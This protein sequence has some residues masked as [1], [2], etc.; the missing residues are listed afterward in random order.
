MSFL[1]LL[2]AGCIDF[3]DDI[4]CTSSS[5][6]PTGYY[7]GTD[8]QNQSNTCIDASGLPTCAD[9]V[10]VDLGEFTI[11][12]FEA[13]RPDATASDEGQVHS[14][15]CSVGGVLPWQLE[16]FDR[17]DVTATEGAEQVCANA[18]KRLCTVDEW[19]RA[20]GGASGQAWPYGDEYVL[21]ACNDSDDDH[22]GVQPTGSY[23][24]CATEEGVYDL[25][26]NLGD[27]VE[28]AS[29]NQIMGGDE[30]SFTNHPPETEG[31]AGSGWE[32]GLSRQPG[33]RCCQ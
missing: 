4:P 26:G 10:V 6:C 22:G 14:V 13:S 28:S 25:A 18:G 23:S 5:G 12:A 21:G 30:M 3:Y 27:L 9:D 33:F 19:A 16:N 11:D 15:A 17:A 29:G 31:C 32:Y 8:E 20:C 2:A 24:T 1:L 7:C